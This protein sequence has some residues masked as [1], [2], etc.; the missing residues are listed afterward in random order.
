MK[1]LNLEWVDKEKESNLYIIWDL[2]PENDKYCVEDCIA[3]IFTYKS[4]FFYCSN[5]TLEEEEPLVSKTLE[6]AKNEVI[7][8][9]RVRL[10][11]LKHYYDYVYDKY[12]VAYKNYK[13]LGG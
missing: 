8:K 11:K 7:D 4:N 5:L 13:Y 6:E 1:K 3:T 9:M 10:N 2:F 12:K